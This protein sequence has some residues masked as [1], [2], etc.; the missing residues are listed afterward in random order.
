MFLGAIVKASDDFVCGDFKSLFGDPCQGINLAGV[1]CDRSGVWVVEREVI[2]RLFATRVT[3][4]KMHYFPGG[5]F[6]SLISSQ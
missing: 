3:L 5:A 6:K 1:C 2:G 4:L